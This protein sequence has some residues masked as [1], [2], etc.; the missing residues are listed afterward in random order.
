MVYKR[1]FKR[2]YERSDSTKQVVSMK[3]EVIP[4]IDKATS[5]VSYV[6]IDPAT[7]AAILN[8][9]DVRDSMVF[10]GRWAEVWRRPVLPKC[11]FRLN[12][13]PIIWFF[14][15]QNCGRNAHY[16]APPLSVTSVCEIQL[17]L[18]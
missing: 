6:V 7:R 18:A 5:T 11:I 3:P 9:S 10:K 14:R 16:C 15:T 1:R 12:P 4:Q 17:T 13:P 8:W 2:N